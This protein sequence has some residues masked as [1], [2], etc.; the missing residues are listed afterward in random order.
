VTNEQLQRLNDE[1]AAAQRSAN[2]SVR[3]QLAAAQAERNG[4]VD[5]ARHYDNANRRI[6]GRPEIIPTPPPDSAAD[7]Q[8]VRVAVAREAL[9]VG[10]AAGL[11]T[12][13]VMGRRG[14]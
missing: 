10:I 5:L 11:A 9:N 2:Q 1:R 13:R 8:R 4:Q 6:L 7:E 14:Y 3:F 12:G